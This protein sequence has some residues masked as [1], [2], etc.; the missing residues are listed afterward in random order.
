MYHRWMDVCLGH[1]AVIALQVNFAQT[2]FFHMILTK[3]FKLRTILLCTIK[4]YVLWNIM[5][6]LYEFHRYFRFSMAASGS[7][8]DSH[9][10]MYAPMSKHTHPRVHTYTH[11]FPLW[12]GNILLKK[13]WEWLNCSW[14]LYIDSYQEIPIWIFFYLSIYCKYQSLNY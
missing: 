3:N 11:I 9:A 13:I 4:M 8:P 6:H 10:C 14:Y 5:Q 2:K 7:I 12:L 1:R